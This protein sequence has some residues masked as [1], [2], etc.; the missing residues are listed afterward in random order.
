VEPTAD[1]ASVSEQAARLLY[2]AQRHADRLVAETEEAAAR[3]R[4]EAE[5]LHGEAARL[6][7]TAAE[8]HAEAVRTAGRRRAPRG[9]RAGAR[10]D[11][12][13]AGEARRGRPA[14]GGE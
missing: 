4:A 8:V 7:A 2:S 9:R 12:H 13:R 10:R 11:H 5:S 6:H 3:M 14:G 1:F